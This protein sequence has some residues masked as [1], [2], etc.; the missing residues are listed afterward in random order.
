MD[1][2]ALRSAI[3]K[4]KGKSIHFS[5]DDEPQK[6][7]PEL[8][9]EI[10]S[11]DD[12]LAPELKGSIEDPS[13]K[14]EPKSALSEEEM[15]E[16]M[17]DARSIFRGKDSQ[18][19]EDLDEDEESSDLDQFGELSGEAL[20]EDVLEALSDPRLQEQLKNGRKA[21]SLQAKV[22]MRIAKLKKK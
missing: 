7:G 22:Q 15:K 6:S 21:N 12:G 19:D 20:N 2:K 10:D 5:M 8:K 13:E 1:L 9:E 18:Q 3:Q 11:D 4:R 17:G 14:S 16:L